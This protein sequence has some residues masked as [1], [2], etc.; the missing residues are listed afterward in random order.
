MYVCKFVRR[1][2]LSLPI[3]AA[4]AGFSLAQDTTS[5]ARPTQADC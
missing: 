2:F 5:L 3:I 1:I 4:L